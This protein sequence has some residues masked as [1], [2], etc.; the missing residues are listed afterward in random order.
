MTDHVRPR[1]SPPTLR[2]INSGAPRALGASDPSMDPP[3]IFVWGAHIYARG[4]PCAARNP[5]ETIV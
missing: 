3:D 2:V 4:A 1:Q 5:E